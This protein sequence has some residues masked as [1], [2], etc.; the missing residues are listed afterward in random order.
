MSKRA[1]GNRGTENSMKEMKYNERFLESERERERERQTRQR[2]RGR[3]RKLGA[4]LY[5]LYCIY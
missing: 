2:E 3:E 5:S 4:S 1:L